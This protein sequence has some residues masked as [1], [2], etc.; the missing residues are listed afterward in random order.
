MLTYADVCG[1]SNAKRLNSKKTKEKENEWLASA[2]FDS[3]RFTSGK[4]N[5]LV[6][7]K[8]WFS[9]CGFSKRVACERALG[10]PSLYFR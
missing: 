1:T 10:Q 2:P 8:Y 7:F 4:L 6:G 9:L 3:P 5:L